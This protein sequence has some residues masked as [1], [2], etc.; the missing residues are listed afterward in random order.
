MRSILAIMLFI[1]CYSALSS[2]MREERHGDSATYNH[3]RVG[4]SLSPNASF[5]IKKYVDEN[6]VLDYAVQTDHLGRRIVPE[7]KSINQRSKFIL[8][9]GDSY[10]MGEGVDNDQTFPYYFQNFSSEFKPYIYAYRGYG[11]QQMLAFLESEDLKSQIAE[12]R[13]L[14]IYSWA[15]DHVHRVAGSPK[16]ISWAKS[17]PYYIRDGRGKVVYSGTFESDR[18]LL[19]QIYLLLNSQLGQMLRL[20]EL[21]SPSG[22]D[23]QLM[24]EVVLASKEII[25][26]QLPLATFATAALPFWVDDKFFYPLAQCME[27]NNIPILDL[28]GIFDGYDKDLI[29]IK[30]DGHGTPFANKIIAEKLLERIRSQLTNTDQF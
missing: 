20:P 24:C 12:D 30:N 14:V 15:T 6:L 5:R 22:K 19:T 8:F 3:P 9:F 18:W 26:Q 11:P 2:Q 27:K 29:H 23:I 28:R 4:L 21:A 13:G 17:W 25:S 7:L 1:F 10:T 16:V